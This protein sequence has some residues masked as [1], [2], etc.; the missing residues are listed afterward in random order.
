MAFRRDSIQ[1][2]DDLVTRQERF[3]KKARARLHPTAE[4]SVW[5][6]IGI[7]DLNYRLNV[8]RTIIS[9]IDTRADSIGGRR[10]L[11]LRSTDSITVQ[12]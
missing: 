12:C 7:D 6:W 11:T 3:N 5:K 9:D 8:A 2:L 10:C 4:E 1:S